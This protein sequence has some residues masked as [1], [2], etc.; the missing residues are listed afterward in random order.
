[1]AN[2]KDGNYA[3]HARY[4]DWSKNDHDRT[5]EDEYWYDYAKKHGNSALIPMCAWG[6]TGAYMVKRGMDV[7]A[8]D[9]TPEMIDEGRK[10]FGDLPGLRLFVGDVTAF[11]FDIPPVDFC[12]SVDFGVIHLL[13]D[14]KKA[15]T[16][17]NNHL[18]P[19]GGLVIETTLPPKESYNWPLQTYMPSKQPYPGLK[20]WKTGSG[21]VDAE[22]GRQY[23]S[24]MFY[25]ED[26]NGRVESFDHSFY[27][28]SYSRDEWLTAFSE[29]GFEV[30]GEYNDRK[31]E[32]WQSGGDDFRIFE[33]VKK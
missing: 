22:T 5:P 18:R 8:F 20:V 29:C 16:C 2:D 32:Y 27:L 33:A 9:I 10:R 17:I 12:Y 30:I 26:E 11:R 4:W 19:G 7:T 23:I 21:R 15:F 13:E 25:T 3:L 24:Q 28:Q 6:E 1:M 31:V 14:I